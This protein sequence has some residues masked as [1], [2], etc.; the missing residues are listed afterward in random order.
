M[1]SATQR[2]KQK[3]QHKADLYLKLATHDAC[4]ETDRQTDRHTRHHTI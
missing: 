1:W 4:L 3:K 2:H